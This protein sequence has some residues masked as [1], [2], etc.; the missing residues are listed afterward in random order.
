MRVGWSPWRHRTAPGLAGHRTMRLDRETAAS[1]VSRRALVG[2]VDQ[3]PWGKVP[4][5]DLSFT[6]QPARVTGFLGPNGAGKSPTTR[7][8]LGLDAPPAG[9]PPSTA[10]PTA[11]TSRRCARSVPTMRDSRF[12]PLSSLDQGTV[13]PRWW[14]RWT[15]SAWMACGLCR[16]K[17]VRP[18][19]TALQHHAPH[20]PTSRASRCITVHSCPMTIRVE[21]RASGEASSV[22]ASAEIVLGE[23]LR[24]CIGDG[25]ASVAIGR[26]RL[27]RVPLAGRA[28][29]NGEDS[30]HQWMD[31]AMPGGGSVRS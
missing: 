2:R 17:R 8:I 20:Q 5:E 15:A 9:R 22:L 24:C 26:R 12:V 4:V 30:M 6:V 21:R 28:R 7:L 10:G 19:H 13:G 3:T 23:V 25:E 18:P 29:T 31:V 16:V 1:D 27:R 11:S 14:R